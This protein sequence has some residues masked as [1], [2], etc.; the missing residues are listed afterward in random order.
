MLLGQTS[1]LRVA[2]KCTCGFHPQQSVR[3]P[4]ATSASTSAA[5]ARSPGRPALTLAIF[6]KA[7]FGGTLSAAAKPNVNL[8][9][10]PAERPSSPATVPSGRSTPS[11]TP[12]R[13]TPPSSPSF[14]RPVSPFS[15]PP[16]SPVMSAVRTS[17]SPLVVSDMSPAPTGP[18]PAP[19]GPLPAPPGPLPAPPGPFPAPPGPLP[20]PPGPL[21]A[22]PGPLPAPPLAAPDQFWLPVE[23]RKNIPQQDQRWIASTLWRNQRLRPD[24]QLWYEPPVPALIYNQV[25]S[26]FVPLYYRFFMHPAPPPSP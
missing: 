14:Y 13:V 16:S 1:I 18:L 23:M 24:V 6:E 20:A 7:W 12:P 19:P 9:W 4:A 17:S 3:S 11:A 15:L 5:P 22:P 26:P 21:P 10:R 25:P 2:Q 8:T